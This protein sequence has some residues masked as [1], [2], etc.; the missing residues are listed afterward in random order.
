[1]KTTLKPRTCKVCELQFMPT[2]PLQ[3]VCSPVCALRKVRADRT[4][5]RQADRAKREALKTL[6]QLTRE[7]QTAFNAW[8]RARDANQP[9]ISCGK[10]AGDLSGLHAGRDAGHYRSVGS[11]SH[12]RFNEDNVHAQ[13]VHCNQWRAGNAVDYRLG[14]LL[15]IGPA[16][17]EA[18]EADNTPR[19]WAREELEAIKT[20]YRAKLRALQRDKELTK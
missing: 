3:G 13:C 9:C 1:M 18:L 6:P 7:A 10:P 2:L 4:A 14:L 8:I 11:A 17:V 12:L 5:E 20:T 19:K 16:R 15:R